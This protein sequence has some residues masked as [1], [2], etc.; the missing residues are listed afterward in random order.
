MKSRKREIYIKT[1]VKSK[2]CEKDTVTVQLSNKALSIYS[3]KDM[4]QFAKVDKKIK[5]R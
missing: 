1:C 4:G 2:I 3:A 5:L